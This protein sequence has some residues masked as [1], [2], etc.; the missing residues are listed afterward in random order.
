MADAGYNPRLEVL[1][2]VRPTKRG[3]I[4]LATS[5]TNLISVLKAS[6]SNPFGKDGVIP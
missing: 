1:V 6:R 3:E 2:G 5:G 4:F